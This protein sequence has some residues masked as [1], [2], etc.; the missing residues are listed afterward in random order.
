[1][2]TEEGR[3]NCPHYFVLVFQ[4]KICYFGYTV[5]TPGLAVANVAEVYILQT[6]V[7]LFLHDF[8]SKVKRP[9]Q[10]VDQLPEVCLYHWLELLNCWMPHC[11]R[12]SWLEDR[13]NGLRISNS[14]G[15]STTTGKEERSLTR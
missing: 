10:P 9:E 5:F 13:S 6:P 11:L 14:S 4:F 2:R 12:R 1:M 7:W 15:G 8:E 3:K